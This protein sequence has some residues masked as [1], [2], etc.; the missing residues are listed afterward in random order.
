M[1]SLVV[2]MIVSGRIGDV[3][4]SSDG[5]GMLRSFVFVSVVVTLGGLGRK[6]VSVRV[7]MGLSMW[8]SMSVVNVGAIRLFVLLVAVWKS[9]FRLLVM[10]SVMWL[11]V[12]LCRKV[13]L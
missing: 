13:G 4:L 12:L 9:M 11:A 10:C 1:L 5:S 3:G 8:D 6:F 2:V 7:S